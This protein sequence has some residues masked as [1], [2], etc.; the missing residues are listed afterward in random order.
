MPPRREPL[1]WHRPRTALRT[2]LLCVVL[3]LLMPA[4]MASAATITSLVG[5][6][7][8]F[9]YGG[10]DTPACAFFDNASGPDIVDGSKVFDFADVDGTD[11]GPWTHTFDL[12]AFTPTSA[13][14]Q[15]GEFFSDSPDLSTITIDGATQPFLTNGPS[16]C[17]TPVVQTFSVPLS[18][19]ADGRVDVVFHQNGDAIALDYAKLVIDGTLDDTPPSIAISSPVD[20]ARYAKGQAVGASYSCDDADGASDVATCDG[21]VA[22]GAA[23]DTSTAGVHQFTVNATDKAG[24]K[25]SKTVTYTVTA[26]PRPRIAVEGVRGSG[27]RCTQSNY[28]I[29]IR[30]T[31]QGVTS[32]RVSVDGRTIATSSRGGRFTALVRASALRRGRHRLVVVARGAGGRT[33]RAVVFTRCAPPKPTFTG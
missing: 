31:G 3:L 5:D 25:S 1:R 2:A 26:T 6:E 9:G 28:R 15:V 20:G 24:N 10:T 13:T 4:T 22:S 14:L 30:A 16:M 12:T 7:D 33:T 8:N 27:R 19:L 18:D 17:D 23:I 21:P 32:V 29:R 11:P